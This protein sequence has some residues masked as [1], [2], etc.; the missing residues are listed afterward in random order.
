MVERLGL[1]Y[2]PI[3]FHRHMDRLTEFM[4]LLTVLSVTFDKIFSD[5]FTQQRSEIGELEEPFD[6]EHQ[7]SSS[8]LPQKR[9]P[10]YCETILAWCKKIR[11][12]A[13]AF[14]ETHM[15]E[16]HHRTGFHMEDLIIPETCI[17][18][19]S[20]LNGAKFILEGL[21][22]RKEVMKRNL[23]ISRGLVMTE[24]LML[25]LSKKTGRKQTAHAIIHKIAMEAFVNHMP[26]SE[27]ILRNPEVRK[28]MTEAEIEGCLKP[29]NHLGLVQK[30][31]D[32]AV[33][34]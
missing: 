15:V 22:V 24:P 30:I 4:N 21:V 7:I 18:V 33:K 16:A 10:F 19:G 13:A 1:V 11:S 32:A 23:D 2:T 31:I 3:S 14:A 8:S 20:L 12:N 34:P 28:Y 27:L 5:I 25:E 9:N 26:F 29:E 6:T 17:L